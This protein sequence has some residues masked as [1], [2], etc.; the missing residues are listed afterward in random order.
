[1]QITIENEQ[2]RGLMATIA[3]PNEM[4]IEQEKDGQ[5]SQGILVSDSLYNYSSVQPVRAPIIGEIVEKRKE[6]AR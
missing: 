2:S 1:M 6:R 5:N 4:S 3:F